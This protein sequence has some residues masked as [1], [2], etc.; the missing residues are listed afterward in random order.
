MIYNTAALVKILAE[1]K[2]NRYQNNK[3]GFRH[4][5]E[6]DRRSPPN[7]VRMT[8][9][10]LHVYHEGV[11]HNEHGPA[12]ISATDKGKVEMRLYY[13]KGN[14]LPCDDI[15]VKMIQRRDK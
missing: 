5:P 13:L 7:G 8:G 3:N 9:N 15:V 10:I 6:L 1:K 4:N 11:L 2:K 12:I 14:K